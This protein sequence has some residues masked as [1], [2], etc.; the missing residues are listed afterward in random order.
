MQ[1]LIC[2]QCSQPFQSA[3]LRTFCSYLC[4]GKAQ[5]GKPRSNRAH[6]DW[7]SKIYIAWRN[8]HYRCR[9]QEGY[10]AKGIAVCPPWFDYLAFKDWALANGY[11]EGLELDR[12]ENHLGY[13][14]ANCRWVTKEKQSENRDFSQ[15]GRAISEYR[16]RSNL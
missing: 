7:Q 3:D 8:M 10:V 6:G 2:Q 16:Q 12:K 1:T 14:P 13:F 15:R 4:R 9:S 11:Q 5:R